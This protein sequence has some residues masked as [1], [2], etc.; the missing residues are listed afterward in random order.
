MAA[1]DGVLVLELVD[2]VGRAL[3]E[4]VDI[5]LQHQVLSDRRVIKKVSATR[6]RIPELFRAPEGRYFVAVDPPS[7]LRVGSIITINPSGDT[8]LRLRFPLDIDKIRNIS[9]P[10]FR[11]LN[12][13][14]QQLLER[15][16]NVLG[17]TG[18]SGGAL[19]DGLDE[20]RRAGLL[21]IAIKAANVGFDAGRTVL[22]SIQQLDQIRGDRFLCTVAPS[23]RDDVKNAVLSGLF[24]EAGSLLHDPPV[25][26]ER[27]GSFKTK[28]SFG[29]LQ[30]TF[31]K[32]GDAFRA[33]IDV[34]DAN[35]FEHFFQVARN[36]LTQKPTHPFNI[37]QILTAQGLD[38][39]Y[40]LEA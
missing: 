8:E 37:H 34:D 22:N 36:F 33:D 13:G 1:K 38:P 21:N 17:H 4:D 31:F 18:L 5:M 15:S 27:F 14:L 6:I 9:F 35:G 29:N 2:V 7:Y 32:Q 39:G 16:T 11:N 30:V 3:A 40:L 24:N 26:F 25:G 28:D 19:Y 12:P 23:L 20:V 10:E